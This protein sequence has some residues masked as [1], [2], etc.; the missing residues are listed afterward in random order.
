MKKRKGFTLIEVIAVITILGIILLLTLSLVSR[1]MGSNKNRKYEVY[2][3]ALVRAAKLYTDSNYKDMFGYNDS[4]CTYID[5]DELKNV[6]LL[7]DFQDKNIKCN[8]LRL[9]NLR[10]KYETYVMVYKLRTS[11]Y[12]YSPR[13]VCKNGL[14]IVYSDGEEYSSDI[15]KNEPDNVKP[16]IEVTPTNIPWV[17]TINAP[18][19]TVKIKDEGIGF[20]GNI[21]LKYQWVKKGDSLSDNWKILKF[22]TSTIRKELSKTLGNK[23]YPV[24]TGEYDLVINNDSLSDAV[25][26]KGLGNDVYLNAK[27]D[28]TP[29]SI[30]VDMKAGKFNS[31]TCNSTTDDYL[32]DTWKNYECVNVYGANVT[33]LGI[34]IISSVTRDGVNYIN[35]G[36]V[37]TIREEGVTSIKYV[38]IDGVG[39]KKEEVIKI[40]LDRKAPSIPT[41]KVRY[42]SS[43]GSIRNVSDYSKW[44]NRSLWWGD[45]SAIDDNSGSGKIKHYEYSTNCTNSKTGNLNSSYLYSDNKDNKYCIRAVDEALN[46]SAWSS[47]Y[48]FKIDKKEPTCTAEVYSKDGNDNYTVKEDGWTNKTIKVK[49]IC[50]D[51]GG[52]GCANS[53]AT[54]VLNTPYKTDAISSNTNT[55]LHAS[56]DN[57]KVVIYDVA[58]NHIECPTALVRVDK[59]APKCSVN[60]YAYD[61]DTDGYTI[62]KTDW[63]AKTIKVKAICSDTGGSGCASSNATTALNT[64]YKTDKITKSDGTIY[65]QKHHASK[66]N[67]K[68]T[69]SDKAGN[70][71]DCSATDVKID[72]KAPTCTTTKSHTGY[73]DGVTATFACT[74]Q[75]VGEMNSSGCTPKKTGLKSS[76]NYAIKDK[77][78]NEGVCSVSI[79][80]SY[81]CTEYERCEACGCSSY[82]NLCVSVKCTPGTGT[83][84]TTFTL[85]GSHSCSNVPAY[86]NDLAYLYMQIGGHDRCE[87]GNLAC[88]ENC[89]KTYKACNK[90]ECKSGV[91]T[92]Y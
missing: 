16:T 61:E 92:Y 41:S 19:I 27:F 85:N 45:F 77:L 74:D 25:G 39:N 31:N 20:K 83:D 50:S 34:G 44:T 55:N 86:N 7:K 71:T 46:T 51:L 70:T 6:N 28:N 15:C 2:K 21:N 58:G 78:G 72:K 56:K 14:D 9:G 67:T 13:L 37:S 11:E 84:P 47:A 17:Q 59:T 80:S 4:G 29:P 23:L 65:N 82:G 42:D 79:S 54:T 35:D 12:Y 64:P 43:N 52:S 8:N 32:T 36:S 69:I 66:D 75:G 91:Y 22:S 76:Q 10:P 40:K 1:V 30:N 81:T 90:C 5:Y 3:D 87:N 88:Q 89:C 57:T 60:M 24:E 53:N 48:T 63:T 62:K 38:A 68:V 18:K 73:S 26:N 33:D 49:A